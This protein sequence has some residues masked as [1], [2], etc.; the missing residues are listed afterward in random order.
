MMVDM[1]ITNIKTYVVQAGL[2]DF[3]LVKIETDSGIFGWGESGFSSR[4]KTVAEMIKQFS[5]FLIGQDPFNISRIWQE[6]YR[7]HYFEGGRVTTAALSALDLALHD[8]KGKALGI[9][10]YQLLG[11]KQ[12]NKVKVFATIPNC[13]SNEIA[14]EMA[15]KI[16]ELGWDCIRFVAAG[17]DHA[18]HKNNFKLI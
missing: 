16:K 4:E 5:T 17:V 1:K 11:G 13:E 9:P 18:M 2:R 3:L 10:V 12:R 6:C 8:I 7:S 14:I 15:L